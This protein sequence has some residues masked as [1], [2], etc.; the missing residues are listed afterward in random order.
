MFDYSFNSMSTT[1]QISINRE[2]FAN[3]MMPVYKLFQ[4]L[5]NTCSRFLP[6]SELSLLN[7]QIGIEVNVS[8][9]MFSIL[10]EAQHF[11]QVTDGIFNPSILDAI[12]NNGYTKSIERI[13]GQ[14]LVLSEKSS[15][16]VKIKPFNLNEMKQTATLFSKIDLAGIAKGWVIDRAV[17]ILEKIGYGFINVGGDIRIFGTLPRP[18]NI[19]IENPFD[20]TKMISSL[21]VSCGAIATSTTMKRRWRVNEE[22]KHHLIDPRTGNP[23]TSKIVSATVTAPTALEADVLAKTVLLLGEEKGRA[24][25]TKRKTRAILINRDEEIWKGGF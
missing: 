3:D 21:Q 6:N 12:E 19:G 7:H 23:S 15:V 5:E 22:W 13:R 10:T 2:L 1:V 14:N 25:I 16:A 20:I 11:F 18:L 8:S 9:E 17:L 4:S 24:V